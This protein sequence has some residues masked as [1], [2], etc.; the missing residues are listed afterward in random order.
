MFTY[1]PPIWTWKRDERDLRIC[2]LANLLYRYYKP[3]HDDATSDSKGLHINVGDFIVLMF[4]EAIVESAEN[5]VSE[6]AKSTR[7]AIYAGRQGNKTYGLSQ[8]VARRLLRGFEPGKFA[9]FVDNTFLGNDADG[10]FS[11]LLEHHLRPG[12]YE[13]GDA[14]E[15]VLHQALILRSRGMLDDVIRLEGHPSTAPLQPDDIPLTS[16][17]RVGNKV[18][19]VGGISVYDIP[20]IP[21]PEH[22]SDEDGLPY[23]RALY[24]VFGEKL[25][26]P[27]FRSEDAEH[28]TGILGAVFRDQRLSYYDAQ[29]VATSITNILIDGEDELDML[30]NEIWSGIIMDYADDH[31]DG[32]TRMRAVLDRATSTSIEGTVLSQIRNL[33]SARVKKGI[34]H[35]LVDDEHIRSWVTPEVGGE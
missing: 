5:P 16:L 12:P 17:R 11:G 15:D 33:L 13:L 20:R 31:P 4:N 10:V 30:E 19:T 1:L 6:L 35:M 25:G 27:Q 29:S 14:C 21:I 32:Y 8:K 28:L 22:I 26:N 7:Q 9:A 24:E 34:C 23:M 2:D 18:M 3:F